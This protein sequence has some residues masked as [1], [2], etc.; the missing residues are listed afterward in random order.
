MPAK[1]M[2]NGKTEDD[3]AFLR[4]EREY[5]NV[6][7]VEQPNTHF[8]FVIAR[9]FLFDVFHLLLMEKLQN[10]KDDNASRNCKKGN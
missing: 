6:L 8:A 2:V 4:I 7:L 1:L 3:V 5:R 10:S 9:Q